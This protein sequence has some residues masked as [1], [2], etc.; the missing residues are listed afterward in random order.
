MQPRNADPLLQWRLPRHLNIGASLIA[1]LVPSAEIDLSRRG[2]GEIMGTHIIYD[3][4]Y[5]HKYLY[6][7]HVYV[8]I[9]RLETQLMFV[10]TGMQVRNGRYHGHSKHRR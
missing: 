10:A 2:M 6:L 4:M 7:T 1:S 9:L 8:C 5:E 3:L